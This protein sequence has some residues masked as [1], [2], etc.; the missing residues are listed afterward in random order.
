M[1]RDIWRRG[2]LFFF[3]LA[4][5]LVVGAG[6]ARTRHHVPPGPPVTDTFPPVMSE[7][8]AV[9]VPEPFTEEESE[10]IRHI[11][12]QM[13]NEAHTHFAKEELAKAIQDLQRLLALHPSQELEFE[14]RWMLA[15]AYQ[16][17]GEWKDARDQYQVL[18]SSPDVTPY[19]GEA[20]RNFQELEALLEQSR[21]P[22]L[23]T[24]AIRLSLSQLPETEGFDEGI[25]RM[26]ADGVTTLLID[27]GCEIR[28]RIKPDS[29]A[30]SHLSSLETMQAMLR[31]FVT[32]SHLQNLLVYIGVSPRCVGFWKEPVPVEWHDRSYDLQARDTKE[33]RLFDLFHPQYQRFLL[34]F[35]DQVAESGV[36]GIIFLG[37]HPMG[38][39][40]GLAQ[41]G[42][43]AF[44]QAFQT[45]F[46][47]SEVFQ[48]TIDLGQLRKPVVEHSIS[49]TP[50]TQETLF[51][52]WAGWKARERLVILERMFH[53]LRRRHL[54]LQVGLE[55]HPHG[56]TDPVRALVEY[57]EDAMEATR[58]PFSFFYVRPEIDRQ[59]ASNQKQVIEKLR[60]ISMKAVLSRLLP[61]L[62][63]PR[64]VWV[65]SPADGRK[66]VT[67]GIGPESTIMGEY[68]AGIG[69]VH[70]LRAFS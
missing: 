10:K 22:P 14:G 68:P 53:H 24:Q 55:I 57:T 42:V 66:R 45:R 63:D 47:V 15:Q 65:S 33:S 32:R 31:S 23:D 61:V 62:D 1:I 2:S 16:K 49:E 43:D 58:R 41:S 50:S 56:L 52:R 36:D 40:D 6:C 12:H 59:S 67:T 26:R 70:D 11:H 34:Q 37:D 51:W 28:S 21:R 46:M 54:T 39:Y 27:L 19:Q 17:S 29:P 4:L 7:D 5:C 13:M 48:R 30:A 3:V 20:K 25:K 8:M 18:A 60:R 35:L 69:V 38:P 9:V 44:Q 64:R